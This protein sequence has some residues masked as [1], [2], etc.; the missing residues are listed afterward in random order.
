MRP[1]C[2]LG[3]PEDFI[4]QVFVR[5]LYRTWILCNQG[6]ALSLKSLGNM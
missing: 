6:F 4:G 2:L 1:A 3:D 5:V